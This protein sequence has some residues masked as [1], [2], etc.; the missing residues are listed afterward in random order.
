MGQQIP[1]IVNCR[2]R[3]TPL[4]ALIE[5]LEGVGQERIVLVDNDSSWEPLLDYYARTPHSVVRLRENLGREAPWIAGVVDAVAGR[6]RYVITDPDIIPDSNCP[7][8]A[9]RHLSYGL[10]TYP[11]YV[12]A[13][14]GLITDDLPEHFAQREDVRRW[15]EQF[16]RRPL[17]RGF[18][19]ANVTTIFAVYR[20]EAQFTSRPAIRASAPYVARHTTWYLDS[21]QLSEEEAFYARRASTDATWYRD[22][23]RQPPPP[24]T[25]LD[26]LKWKR[27]AGMENLRRVARS[28]LGA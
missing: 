23:V 2:D 24:M 16:S 7:P 27:Y 12:K 17:G 9:I 13:G 11:R 21:A 25:V 18:Y 20:E 26:K 15:E 28:V 1:V 5:W 10:D 19:H 8:D 22:A 14:L 6:G 3:V 4:I